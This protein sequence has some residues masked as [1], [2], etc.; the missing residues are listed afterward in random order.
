M[1]TLAFVIDKQIIKQDPTCDFSGLV[2]GTDGYLQASFSFSPE[3]NGC[4]KVASFYTIMGKECKPQVLE[5][6]KTCMIPAEALKGRAFKIKV[7][8]VKKDFAITSDRIV[9]FQNGGKA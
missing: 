9:V 2:P 6:G 5:D 8:G 1:R 7:Y 4:A 3:W